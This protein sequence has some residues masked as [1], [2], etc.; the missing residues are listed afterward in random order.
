VG[1]HAVKFCEPQFDN[2]RA[3]TCAWSCHG[4]RSVITFILRTWQ[5]AWVDAPS[6]GRKAF[7]RTNI[8]VRYYWF[9]S[10]QQWGH[11]FQYCSG[12]HILE[13]LASNLGRETPL[14]WLR[15]FMGFAQS[16]QA[17][18]GSASIRPRSPRSSYYP[19]YWHTN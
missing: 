9:A 3:N 19:S 11:G 14:S 16:F 6:V 13:V 17:S 15:I 10:L 2:R 5:T 1:R 18:D 4:A 12:S 7:N 8:E